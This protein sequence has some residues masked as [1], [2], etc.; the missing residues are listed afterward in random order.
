ML[1]GNSQYLV[2]TL[3]ALPLFDGRYSK[4]KL[5]NAPLGGAKRG[6]FSLVFRAH[7]ELM[8]RTVALKFFDLDPAKSAG[9]Y[10][11][12]CFEREHQIL[13]QLRGASRCLQVQ[14]DYAVY[15]LEIALPS[16]ISLT[17]L[18]PYFAVDWFEDDIDEYFHEQESKEAIEKLKLFN[19]V[20][21]AVESLHKRRVFHRDLKVDNFRAQTRESERDVVAI[22]LGTA[23]RYDST[24]IQAFYGGP[25]GM[26]MYSAPEAFCGMS[27]VRSIAPLSDV[28][29]LGCMLFELFHPDDFPAAFRAV[30]PDYDV[31]FAAL[32]SKTDAENTEQGKIDAWSREAPR[33]LHG[34]TTVS[35][36]NGASSAPS[37]IAE[38]LTGIVGAMAAPDFRQRPVSFEAIRERCWTAIR[39]LQNEAL[40]KRR[41][42][43]AA[44]KRAAK[45]RKAKARAER[46]LGHKVV[47]VGGL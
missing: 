34:L 39:V 7:D 23:A 32:R 10:R 1:H 46:A 13:E 28:F 21:L 22:D 16:G 25:V 35:L 38:L 29:A 24:P 27:A 41:A 30:N 17:I 15:N 6:Y 2:D 43:Q 44:E 8:G 9:G 4:L 36:L 12:K 31:R 45:A 18:A 40:A 19:E 47:F 20:I 3:E 14:S 5:I 37:C 33:L 42:Q 26:L 11:V